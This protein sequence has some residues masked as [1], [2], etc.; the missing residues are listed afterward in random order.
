MINALTL[1]SQ[2]R[3][4]DDAVFTRCCFELAAINGYQPSA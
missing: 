2:L 4:P 3:P 1:F